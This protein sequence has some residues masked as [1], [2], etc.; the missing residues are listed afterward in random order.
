[1]EN[2][3]QIVID[4][5]YD[6]TDGLLSMHGASLNNIGTINNENT[7][8]IENNEDINE[9]QQNTI[10]IEEEV[11][12]GA[13][14]QSI[15][16][17]LL[18]AYEGRFGL[19]TLFSSFTL[20]VFSKLIIDIIFNLCSMND[21]SDQTEQQYI[22]LNLDRSIEIKMSLVAYI[23]YFAINIVHATFRFISCISSD[24]NVTA[25]DLIS[26]IYIHSVYYPLICFMAVLLIVISRFTISSTGET[27]GFTSVIKIYIVLQIVF[28]ISEII[29]I[30]FKPFKYHLYRPTTKKVKSII[31]SIYY[32]NH[33]MLL[34]A[35]L[36][37][38]HYSAELVPLAVV[39]HTY[40][41]KK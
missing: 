12:R 10:V 4:E 39:N 6:V 30:C 17:Y 29:F 31:L 28:L 18:L 24:F 20:V 34:S 9:L 23:I 37:L 13:I 15:I 5:A 35:L 21:H 25:Y 8:E 41:I 11:N 3:A 26:N 2:S 36:I 38:I 1:M 33:I 14:R 19:Y 27:G 16:K 40:W 22:L 7:R 32:I